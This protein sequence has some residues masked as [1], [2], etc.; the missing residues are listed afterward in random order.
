M[1]QGYCQGRPGYSIVKNGDYQMIRATN[2]QT[3]GRLEFAKAV[4][5]GMTFEISIILWQTIGLQDD[6]GKCLQCAYVNPSVDARNGWIEWRVHS[7]QFHIVVNNFTSCSRICGGQFHVAKAVLSE[8]DDKSDKM[9]N[10]PDDITESVE[11]IMSPASYVFSS[12]V[13]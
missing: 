2:G 4:E 11:E 12:I 1:I 3:I 5:P 10:M 8:N 7:T 9:S 13:R 6:E